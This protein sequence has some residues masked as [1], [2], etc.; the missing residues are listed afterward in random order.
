[1]LSATPKCD[2][3]LFFWYLSD[4]YKVKT[5]FGI[6]TKKPTIEEEKNYTAEFL[7]AGD[8]AEI[9][10]DENSMPPLKL[11]LFDRNDDNATDGTINVFCMYSA[12]EDNSGM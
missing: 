12:A 6:Y 10:C 4:L 7:D 1:M 2:N 5:K 11:P 9:T 3:S 8:V